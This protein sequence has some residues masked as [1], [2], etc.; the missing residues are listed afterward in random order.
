MNQNILKFVSVEEFVNYEIKNAIAP[1]VIEGFINEAEPLMDF[2]INRAL[3]ESL[4]EMS[5]THLLVKNDFSKIMGFFSLSTISVE[6]T[7]LNLAKKPPYRSVPGILIGRLG[8]DESAKGQ[9]IGDLLMEEIFRLVINASNDF[10]IKIIITDAKTDFAKIFYSDFG[11]KV[12]K[13]HIDGNYPIR[14][15]LEV[16]AI[17]KAQQV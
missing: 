11:F 8:R 9:G 6:R 14:M 10:G 5:K 17:K 16:G 13:S 1:S 12:V 7:D 3:P 2:L 15:Y 4:T